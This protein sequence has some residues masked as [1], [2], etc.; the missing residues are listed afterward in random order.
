MIMIMIMITI[1][2]TSRIETRSRSGF[3]PSRF[4]SHSP[5]S[6]ALQPGFWVVIPL[7]C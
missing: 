2:I 4:L 3:N 1:T 5:E 7:G 6:R